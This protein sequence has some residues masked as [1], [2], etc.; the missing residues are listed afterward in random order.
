MV[1]SGTALPFNHRENFMCYRSTKG[2]VQLVMKA[3][4]SNLTQMVTWTQNGHHV[5]VPPQGNTK[6]LA[7]METFFLPEPVSTKETSIFSHLYHNMMKT[8][9]L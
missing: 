9:A 4:W 7:M 8:T 2:V 6:F 3:C 1:C 5:Y